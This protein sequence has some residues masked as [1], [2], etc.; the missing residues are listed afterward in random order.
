MPSKWC[1]LTKR[2]R[3]PVADLGGVGHL[4]VAVAIQTTWE[5]TRRQLAAPRHRLRPR[6]TLLLRKAAVNGHFGGVKNAKKILDAMT[7][8]SSC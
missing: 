3:F 4:G 2:N 6:N 5:T 7:L 1:L 8:L